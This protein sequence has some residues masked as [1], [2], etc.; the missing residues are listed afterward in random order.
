[1]VDYH[2]VGEGYTVSRE[3]EVGLP[4]GVAGYL[5]VDDDLGPY[6]TRT[7]WLCAVSDPH[8]YFLYAFAWPNTND[9]GVLTE[10]LSF[11]P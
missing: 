1:M 6:L 9:A 2:V 7:Y 4:G 3:T 11:R 10:L 5:I 8:V